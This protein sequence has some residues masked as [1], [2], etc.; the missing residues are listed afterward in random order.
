MIKTNRI[1]GCHSILYSIPEPGS[2]T[3]RYALQVRQVIRINIAV[4]KLT[5]D[6]FKAS[7]ATK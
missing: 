4:M 6:S 3:L 1:V 5:S 2:I 7:D